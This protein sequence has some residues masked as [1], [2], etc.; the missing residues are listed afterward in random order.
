MKRIWSAV[1]ILCLF[2]PV[3]WKYTPENFKTPIALAYPY[4]IIFGGVLAG[5]IAGRYVKK[6]WE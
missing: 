2:A 4:L 5:W 3:F 6:R 1:L